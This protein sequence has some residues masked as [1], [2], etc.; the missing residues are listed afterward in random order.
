M[1]MPAAPAIAADLK[2]R[3]TADA[4][5]IGHDEVAGLLLQ[6]EV[7]V[8]RAVDIFAYLDRC[9]QFG[10]EPGAA[11]EIVVKDRFL[12]PDQAMTVNHVAAPQGVGE[13]E[14]LV[15]IDHQVDILADRI[16][17]RLYGREVFA[18]IGAAQ[19]KLQGSESSAPLV[20]Q[21]DRLGGRGFGRL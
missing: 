6:R 11:V 12:D 10:G 19:P 1:G 7:N 16:P 17:H 8:A 3:H 14:G 13:I 5:K 15:E 18:W 2:S 4:H 9:L 20:E 21:F